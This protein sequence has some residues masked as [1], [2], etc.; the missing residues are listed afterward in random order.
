MSIIF[1]L[2]LSIIALYESRFDTARRRE[3]LALLAE[4]DEFTEEDEDPQAAYV[5]DEFGQGEDREMIL[6]K[7]SFAELK[8][9]LPSLVRSPEAEILY[10]VSSLVVNSYC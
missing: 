1:F 3:Y 10:Q 8:A 5:T 6:S 9:S 2:P 4:P 7:H